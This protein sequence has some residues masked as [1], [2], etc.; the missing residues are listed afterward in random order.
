MLWAKA[1]Y[2]ACTCDAGCSSTT[3]ISTGFSYGGAGEFCWTATDLGAYVQ[4][5]GCDVLKI[6]GVDYTN[7]YVPTGDLIR[8]T[9]GKYYIYY[10]SSTANG[11]FHT[12]GD[13][14]ISC[15]SACNSVWCSCEQ[16]GD[17]TLNGY[18][19]RND[20]WGS[21][22][23]GPQCIW[24]N[25]PSNWGVHSDQPNTGGV[26]S[27]P[28][29]AYVVN[30]TISAMGSCSST[31]NVT[32]PTG[33]AYETAWDIWVP[34]E[35]MIWMNKY[36]A[37][38]PIAEAWNDDGTPVAS[39]TNVTVGG[40]TWD[41]YHGGSNVV[42]FVRQG[43]I[44][45]G[46]VDIKAIL[47]WIVNKGWISSS[48]TVSEVQFGFEITSSAGGLDFTCN[49]YSIGGGGTTT[50]TAASTTTTAAST[51]TTAASTT[52]TAA[53]TTTHN[54]LPA[55][56]TTATPAQAQQQLPPAQ[57][58]QLLQAQARPPLPQAQQR[59]PQAQQQLPLQ[60]A[61]VIL[62]ATVLP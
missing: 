60:A 29:V 33:G 54:Q 19:I 53:S 36:G 44:S 56:T 31:F 27:Y 1:A 51:T 3:A 41:V 49:S 7:L 10:K 6:T 39:A 58:T 48:G 47:D 32:V 9:T 16:Y 20:I 14:I 5:W 23:A 25:S 35:V 46:T 42:S 24:V 62:D 43:N 4:S 45:S 2:G 28:H 21:G 55:Q 34:S 52:T 12:T 57:H 61:L 13:S 22:S 38:G 50:T 30:K 11:H 8:D 59:L 17:I 15:C 40:H 37:V 18:I 26:K